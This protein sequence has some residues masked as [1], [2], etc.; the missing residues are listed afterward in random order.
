[1][2]EKFGAMNVPSIHVISSRLEEA[3]HWPANHIQRLTVNR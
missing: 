2:V 3:P 1:L